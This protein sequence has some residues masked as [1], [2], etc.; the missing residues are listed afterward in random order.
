MVT[1][2]EI[3]DMLKVWQNLL[4]REGRVGAT[5]S[6][7]PPPCCPLLCCHT[8]AAP[9]PPPHTRRS[10]CCSRTCASSAARGAST[11]AAPARPWR[12]ACAST[13][14]R[15]ATR[16]RPTALHGCLG[17]ASAWRKAQGR[18]G[19]G[20]GWASWWCAPES[21]ELARP[22]HIASPPCLC[23]ACSSLVAEYNGEV[24]QGVAPA[25][26]VGEAAEG[27]GALGVATNNYSRTE[28]Q[29]VGCVAGET[30]GGAPPTDQ[31]CFAL[32]HSHT[33][34]LK[35][36]LSDPAAAAVSVPPPPTCLPC[37]ALQQLHHRS[38]LL[39]RAGAPRRRHQLELWRGHALR[40]HQGSKG[41]GGAWGVGG[42]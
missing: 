18:Q 20:W 21:L 37:P 4:G 3:G 12:T 19:W 33:H 32:F 23:P 13:C 5:R 9:S 8:A 16:E 15:P 22:P 42:G 36:A 41:Q 29:N 2:T 38:A 26:A 35:L 6:S 14:Y 31:P 34:I 11:P 39:A 1:S 28:G 30:G 25:T 10:P 27:E 7:P 40:H 24:T 17:G